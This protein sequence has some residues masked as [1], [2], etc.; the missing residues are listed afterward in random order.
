MTGTILDEIGSTNARLKELID[1]AKKDVELIFDKYEIDDEYALDYITYENYNDNCFII[2]LETGCL[3]DTRIISELND[4]FGMT[5]K[6]SYSDGDGFI[7][8][9]KW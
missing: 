6:L 3:I 2:H 5:G 9:Y 1:K 8:Y 4:Y 7:I